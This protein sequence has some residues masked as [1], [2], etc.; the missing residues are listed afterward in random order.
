MIKAKQIMDTRHTAILTTALTLAATASAHAVVPH[1]EGFEDLAWTANQ[2]GNWQNYDGGDIV[3]VASGT[4]GIISSSGDAHAIITNLSEQ[5]NPVTSSTNLG[6][7]SPYT[8]FG[9]YS[10]SFGDG[11]ATSLDIY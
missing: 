6:V 9:G 7:A 8:Q 2:T 10:D 1:F 5:I 4:N 11:F 3:R